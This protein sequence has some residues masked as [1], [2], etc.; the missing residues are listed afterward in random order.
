MQRGPTISG[1]VAVRFQRRKSHY[2][3]LETFADRLTKVFGWQKSFLH[4]LTVGIG[5]NKITAQAESSAKFLA[6]AFDDNF[7][8]GRTSVDAARLCKTREVA[9]LEQLG[10]GVERV[11]HSFSTASVE[12]MNG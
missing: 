1:F 12:R 2:L 9:S 11:I 6:A 3:F 7:L 4:P 5:A 10:Q 8:R